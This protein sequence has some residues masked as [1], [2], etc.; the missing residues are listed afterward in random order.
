MRCRACGTALLPGKSFCH[1]CGARA[2]Q[3]CAHCGAEVDP[4]FR[5]CPDCGHPLAADAT[6][7]EPPPS[8]VP[9]SL[10]QKIRDAQGLPGERKQVTVL[11]CDLA[12]STAVAGGL[13]P[14]VYREVLEQYVALAMHEIYRFE[15]IVNQLSGDGFMALFGAPVAHEDAPQRAVL[16]ALAIRDALAHFNEQLQ[17]ERGVA[18]PARIGLNTGPVVVGTVG[19]D[20]KMDYTAIGDTTNLAA[21]LEQLAR[22]GSILISETT[23]RLVRGF[24]RLRQV[25][26]L[27]VKG[28]SEPV[29]AY[30]VLE[31]REQTNP[32]SVAA[33]RGLTPFV[34]RDEELAQLAG[35]FRR[36]SG[37]YTQVVS[38]VG[39]AGSG[40]SRVIYEFK[41][42]LLEEGEPVYFFEG[43]CAALNQSIPLAPFVAMLRQYFD[44][45]SSD[46]EDSACRKVES[47]LGKAMAKV[48]DAYPLLCRVLS[49]PAQLPADLPLEHLKRETFEAIAKLV[50]TESR[51]A[52]VVMILED[53]HWIDE[54]SQELLEMAITR[55]S[56][57]QV[58]ILVSHRP[59]Y[60][61]QWRTEAAL[62]QVHLRPLLDGDALRIARS[63]A[64]GPLPDELEARILAKAEGSPFFVEEITRSLNEEGFL[65]VEYGA[66]RLTRPVDEI[67]IPGSVREVIA[68]RLDRLPAA[69]KRVAQIAAV[70]GRQFHRQQLSQL[71]AD[72]QVDVEHEL[73]ELRR[74]GVIHRKSLFSDDEYRFGES[75][76]QEVAYDSLLH[77]QRRQLHGRVAALLET[78]GG[79]PSLSRPAL[80]AH[81]FARSDDRARAVET[82]LRAAAEAEQ[83]PS[84]RTALDLYRQAW[85]IG[86]ALL[87]D[88]PDD[89]KV[90]RW[91]M[92]ATVGYT[93]VTVLYGSSAD[94]DAERAALR[95]RELAQGLGVHEAAGLLRTLHGMLLTVDPERFAEGVA[96]TEA[97][98]A[99]ARQSGDML[100]ALSASRAVAWHYLLDGRFDAARTTIEWVE[101][102]LQE[103]AELPGA[104]EMYLGARMMHDGI[105][106]AS[107]ELDL[108]F[109]RATETLAIADRG[110]NHTVR[111]G[112]SV[113]LAQLHLQRA[114][115]AEARR[116]A[117]RGLETAEQIGNFS[118]LQ[119]AR[120]LLL[121]ARVSLGEAVTIGTLGDLLEEGIQRGGNAIVSIQ[122]IV[123]AFLA[124]GELGRAER[125]ARVAHERAAGRYRQLLAGAALSDVLV[126]LGA[127]AW[128]EAERHIDRT[129][130]IA[131]AVGARAIQAQLSVATARLA[132]DRDLPHDAQ[133]ALERARTLCAAIGLVRFAGAIPMLMAQAENGNRATA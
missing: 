99:E 132:L 108:A 77:R 28:K 57:A 90:Q 128:A 35:C 121:A 100:Q 120:A 26:P 27:E 86:E 91:V 6:A 23:A 85:E 62:T 42:R 72:E 113:L 56:R 88:T 44:L 131:E 103:R 1:A 11:F 107:D 12:G 63:L 106:Q 50:Q 37:Q 38:L 4:G 89:T 70:L 118:G 2:T 30:E 75:L 111:A 102:G 78:G 92:E 22:P 55:L 95:G 53:L 36:I 8:S 51:R 54:P 34:G 60:R 17:R 130:G 73:E 79:D 83:L 126:R 64:G 127:S 10:A 52:P 112:T 110:A 14:E 13:D 101:R 81:H 68:A 98:V 115:Y 45:S 94:A 43:R 96:I 9:E 67:L 124:L 116:W 122:P 105:L 93:R 80:L 71:L 16:A 58:M 41:Q 65:S 87:T 69:A 47:R 109:A 129:M 3:A 48:D 117:S 125:V 76:T 5:F 18:L 19:N 74:R 31:A 104:P 114:E 21:R 97:A 66:V 46:D 59:E 84:F 33:E 40:K 39:A 32:M 133:Q 49:V 15:G 7:A 24:A 119:R 25:G 123:D 61:P 82:L 29:T 20:L